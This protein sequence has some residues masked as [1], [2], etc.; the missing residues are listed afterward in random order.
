MIAVAAAAATL[1]NPYGWGLW[2]YLYENLSV[3]GVVAIAELL[4]PALP[5]YRA[6]YFYL[7][8][9]ATLLVVDRRGF[10]LSDAVVFAV[11]ATFG[12]MHLRE[13]PLVLCVTAPAVA[14]R[15]AGL[16]ARGLD[17][18]AILVTSFCAALAL[19]RIPPP[20]L[21]RAFAIGADAVEPPQFFSRGAIDFANR[22]GLSGPVFNSVNLGGYI[23]WKMYPTARVFQDTRFQAY[24]PEHFRSI[25]AASASQDEWNRLVDGCRLGN[26]LGAEAEPAL[27][28]RTVSRLGVAERLSGRRDRDR[29]EEGG[30]VWRSGQV[31]TTNFQLPGLPRLEKRSRLGIS[32][33]SWK[34]GALSLGSTRPQNAGLVT[35]TVRAARPSLPRVFDAQQLTAVCA[36]RERRARARHAVGCARAVLGIL[37]LGAERRRARPAR[38]RRRR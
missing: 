25:I 12:L 20:V 10:A 14:Q 7:A 3:Q 8:L 9:T 29:G 30:E 2:Q 34:L 28:R 33:G 17:Y 1:L 11:F 16:T 18:R 19:S 26:G 27:R 4:P 35:V 22:A 23:A 38:R 31:T 37:R 6:F 5:G 13:T 32:F 15:L 36:D 21:L 24:P